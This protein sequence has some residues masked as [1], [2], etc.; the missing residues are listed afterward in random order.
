MKNIFSKIL[1]ASAT[2]LALAACDPFLN[3]EPMS[4]IS[5]EGYYSSDAQVNASLIREYANILPGNS[6]GYGYLGNDV[7]TDNQMDAGMDNKFLNGMWKV[8]NSSSNWSF[9]ALYYVNYILEQVVPKFEEGKITGNQDNIKHYIGETYF[10]RAYYYYTKLTRYGDYPIIKECLPDDMEVL[11]EASKRAPQNEVARFI[12]EDLDKA[13]SLM[14]N[15]N[16]GTTRINKDAA[17]ILKSRVALF[18]GTWL[19][20]HKGTAMVPGGPEWPGGSSYTYP[21]GSIDAESSWFLNQAAAAAKEVADKYVDRL[22]D[23]TGVMQQAENETPN[24]Y[25]NMFASVDLSGFPEVVMWR[26]YSITYSTHSVPQAAGRGNYLLGLT[27]GYVQN[28]LMLDGSPIYTHGT[29]ADGDGYYMGDKTLADVKKNRDTRL[30][31]FLKAPGEKNVCYNIGDPR[32]TEVVVTEPYPT[33]TLGDSERGYT[34]GYALHKGGALDCN[35]YANYGGY[36]G[37][38]TFRAVEALLN[39]MEASYEIS[40]NVDATADKYWRAIRK[41]A[42]V[43]EDYMNTVNLTDM[44]KEGEF[45][46]GAYSAGVLMTDKVLYNIRRERRT[47]LLS[48]GF[49]ND[50]L[51]RWKSY[52]CLLDGGPLAGFQPEGIHL[53]NTPME[54]WYGDSLIEGPDN[55]KANVSG[56]VNSEYLRVFQTVRTENGYDGC[57]W[58]LA[59]YFDPIPVSEILLNSEDGVSASSSTIYQNP[60]WP[61]EADLS[62]TK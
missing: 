21:A 5:P 51:R 55:P 36:T 33:I 25:Y 14:G 19:K 60:Y 37:A 56:R 26:Q 59:H 3:R 28:F 2:V 58:H 49:R 34:T 50:D 44:A 32:G 47:E 11:R 41:R 12:L 48:E 62:A 4:Q 1:L 30:S 8:P 17:L 57:H 18:E 24:P 46:W 54:A 43:N 20:Y 15:L 38:I 10:L 6:G 52:D 13:V 16:L 31:I 40:G 45:D 22:T 42:K 9:S 23:N 27:R 35:H 7:D 39:Y 53:W 29:Y 61:V